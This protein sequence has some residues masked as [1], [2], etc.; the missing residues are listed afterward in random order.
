M[1]KRMIVML[2]LVV[3]L[4]AG[5][6]FVKFRQIQS[7]VAASAFQPPPEAVTSIVAKREVWPASM[8]VIGSMA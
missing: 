7:G 2:G 1:A 8:N 5:L 6:G 3:V 4:L